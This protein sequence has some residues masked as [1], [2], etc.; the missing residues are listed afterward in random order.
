M[1]L[2]FFDRC[3]WQLYIQTW[4]WS[5]VRIHF[6]TIANTTLLSTRPRGEGGDGTEKTS[7]EKEGTL[8]GGDGAKFSVEVRTTFPAWRS[9]PLAPSR[10]EHRVWRKE[11]RPSVIG[12]RIIL[13]IFICGQEADPSPTEAQKGTAMRFSNHPEKILRYY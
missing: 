3:S 10:H 4:V 7:R 5:R 8:I 11:V 9:P 1:S 12:A 13:R 2:P 6:Q